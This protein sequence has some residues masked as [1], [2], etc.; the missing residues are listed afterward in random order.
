[1]NDQRTR[2]R[3]QYPRRTQN[4]QR[5]VNDQNHSRGPRLKK[6]SWAEDAHQPDD[7]LIEVDLSSYAGEVFDH[8]TG[9][10]DKD[11]K[12]PQ[13]R[14]TSRLQIEAVDLFHE[15]SRQLQ[16]HFTDRNP[17]AP[18][19]KRSNAIRRSCNP[20]T[21]LLHSHQAK[22]THEVRETAL[23]TRQVSMRPA[24]HQD[25]AAESLVHG[26]CRPL[27]PVNEQIIRL[28]RLTLNREHTYPNSQ[29][30]E[31]QII[32]RP[33]SPCLEEEDDPVSPASCTPSLRAESISTLSS[34]TPSPCSIGYAQ[35]V[36]LDSSR[37]ASFID[38]T[39]MSST[40]GMGYDQDEFEE[41]IN[42]GAGGVQIRHV[43]TPS[44]AAS[45]NEIILQESAKLYAISTS[46]RKSLSSNITGTE[47]LGV[48]RH[49]MPIS[50]TTTE[51]PEHG[52]ELSAGRETVIQH[53]FKFRDS[54]QVY[55]IGNLRGFMPC[56]PLEDPGQQKSRLNSAECTG[57]APPVPPHQHQQAEVSTIPPWLSHHE[58][59][60]LSAHPLPPIPHDIEALSSRSVGSD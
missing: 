47:D 16:Q 2:R 13:D 42:G 4:P 60:R 30:D 20:R 54:V 9:V 7:E 10:A 31:V 28:R 58:V 6:Q 35:A 41:E 3:P 59:R 21:T 1:M 15:A 24:D 17:Q 40:L 11:T 8:I 29:S 45:S 23:K 50:R 26:S 18:S 19:L 48:V 43:T 46:T 53:S 56:L 32:P 38:V 22:G 49:G 51:N 44:L 5:R 36:H 27:S 33:L 34:S 57:K 14:D 39:S 52:R 25:K 12:P 55:R 37:T